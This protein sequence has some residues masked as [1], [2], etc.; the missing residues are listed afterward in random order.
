MHP[1]FISPLR[2][3]PTA[4]LVG[5]CLW[6]Q[7]GAAAAAEHKLTIADTIGR[8][9]EQEPI[10]WELELAAGEWNGGAVLVQRDGKPI[11]AQAEVSE[12]H[13]DGSARKAVIRFLIARL[14]ANASTT[15]SA[16][17][18][19]KGP[20]DADLKVTEEKGALV[21]ESSHTAAKVLNRNA[22]GDGEF[23][24][25]LAVRT[26][27]GHW[28]G[29]GRYETATAKPKAT[30]TEL[31]E[32]GPVRLAARVTTTF[33]NSR[34]HIVTVS[35]WAGSRCIDIEEDFNLGPD[36]KY[37][38]K[39]Y[40]DDRDELCWE[41]WSWYGDKDGTQ[42][43]HP[44][45]WVLGLS[46]TDF[47][48]LEVKWRGESSTDPDKGENSKRGE[49]GYSLKYAAPKRLEKYL[50]GH[51]QWRPDAVTWYG[52]SPSA[53]PKADV[54]ALFTH[55]QPRWRNPNVLPTPQGIT[56]RTGANDM[57]ICSFAEGKRLAVECPIGLGHR[58]WAI[59]PSTVEETY[60][61]AGSSPTALSDEVV[62]R[63]LGL[64]LTRTWVTDWPVKAAYPH[65]FID[66]K[67]KDTY[68]ARLKGQGIGAPG[69]MLDFFLRFQDQG[70]FDKDYA[71]ATKLGD[72]LVN[73][74]FRFGTDNTNGYPD[75]MLAYWHAISI[76]NMLDNLGGSPLCR[77]E[78]LRALRKRV[79]ICMYGLQLKWTDKQT[80]YG[81]GSM[82][83]PVGRWGGQVVSAC[84][85]SDHPMSETWLK[86]AARYF[87][88]L[89]KTEYSPEGVHISC[90]HYIGASSTSFYAWIALANSGK[91]RDVS[92]E[93]ALKN[94]ARYYMQLMTPIDPRWGIRTLLCEGD[95]RPGSSPFPG[96]L[97][98]LFSKSD[99][100]LAGQLMQI[101][102]E[103]GSDLSGGMGV[104]DNLIID[105]S[106]PSVKP[107]L[108]SEVFPGFGAML[109]NRE[110]GTAEESYLAFMGGDFM[111]D[112]ANEDQLSFHWHETGVPLSIFCGSM[113]N[114]M[115]CTA[116]SHNTVC[117]DVKPGGAK[118]P[119]KDQPGNWYHDNN[120]P[121][122]DLGGVRPTLHLEIGFDKETQKI[123]ETRGMVTAATDLAE[124]TLLEGR[125]L[126]RALT[127]VPTRPDNYA[128]AI[129]SQAWPP[130]RKL[131]AP[132][133]WTRRLLAV[134]AP[135]AAGMNYLV[136]RDDF[137]GFKEHTP[138]FSYWA[139][140]DGVSLQGNAANFQG[141]LGVDADM[142][143]LAPSKFQLHKGEFVNKE[144]EPIVS[145]LHQ[146]RHGK[147]F[148]EK[149]ALCRVE[150]S[151]GKGFFVVIF[152]Y[153]KGGEAPSVQAWAGEAGVK[154]T[155][156]GETH[157]VLLE[158]AD[159]EVNADGLQ[160]RASATVLKTRA[161]DFSLSL[162]VGG[163]ASFGGQTVEGG[164]P[165]GVQVANGKAERIEGKNL[166][167]GRATK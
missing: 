107:K 15:V 53:D 3:L 59:R 114:P 14:E 63:N 30:K 21:L 100:D 10:Q 52:V 67:N 75:C 127:E 155:W 6:T 156:K 17:L 138:S 137:G 133:T 39:E 64:D 132:F 42:E 18:G 58:V 46:S 51:G 49:S 62:R 79:A 35:L 40:K 37:R 32:K 77:P 122:V 123:T 12:R 116:L 83:M 166:M 136:I 117:W 109:R 103:G 78:Q 148:E 161:Q 89:L 50:A 97:G 164:G 73:G 121:Y 19:G 131:A 158:M 108:R 99:P 153:K 152:P 111:I 34:R 28:V 95:S 92:Q 165:A 1:H 149:Q 144:C 8:A 134:K 90:P 94:F 126:V 74:Y 65:L 112:H 93:P 119:G 125:V 80:N 157:Y 140:A 44:N 142:V 61:P 29:G 139:L 113:Y 82:N 104:P 105:P 110:L 33:D 27:S 115:T 130:P 146:Q 26:A 70:N 57:R 135:Q 24:P 154:V 56:L 86:D 145:R 88:M 60:A 41:W 47:Q 87:E 167:P 71:L 54:V 150:G 48:P 91:F 124:A 143:V 23:S 20:T 66:P 2:R 25:L 160:A 85:L 81:W 141:A 68:F 36:D 102:R 16:E 98:T 76:A 55:S 69:N 13:A 22:D 128:I 163:K 4:V 159:R 45:N 151:P 101:W 43:T 72:E 162:P 96:I 118:G 84:A 7:G 38:L 5:L 120:Q 31:L 147:P 129:A 11:P 106:V 9:W